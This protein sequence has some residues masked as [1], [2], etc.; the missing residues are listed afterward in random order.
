MKNNAINPVRSETGTA[1]SR[2]LAF[3]CVLVMSVTGAV[4]AQETTATRPAP[5]VDRG[6]TEYAE[7]PA[8]IAGLDVNEHLGEKLPLDADLIDSTGAKVKLGDWFN[9]GKPVLV[10]FV[11][12]RCPLACPQLLERYAATYR[13]IDTL[14]IGRDYNVLVISVDPSD[15]P[16]VAAA[17]K[18]RWLTNYDRRPAK[19]VSAG[20]AFLTSPDASTTRRIADA[21][22][23]PYRYLPASNDYSHPSATFVAS[24]TGKICRYLYGLAMPAQTLRLA[25]VEAGEGKIGSSTDKILLWCFH[26][27]PRSGAYTFTAWRIMQVGGFLSAVLVAALLSR[28]MMYEWRRKFAAQAAAEAAEI[29]RAGAATTA[30]VTN[31]IK[32][33][34]GPQTAEFAR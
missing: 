18:E 9:Q 19:D 23:F 21:L 13:E 26:F 10:M 5:P 8:P 30:A 2:V 33:G 27:D 34:T 20:W 14:T 32:P 12:F 31:T 11:Y 4:R 25:L 17:L 1:L 6:A 22:G 16:D 15:K 7:K 3:A 28:M 24:P 29:A